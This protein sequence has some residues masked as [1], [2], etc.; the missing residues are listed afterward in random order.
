MKPIPLVLSWALV[1]GCATAPIEGPVRGEHVFTNYCSPCHGADA[2]GN[3]AYGAPA[4]AGLPD[5]YLLEQLHKYRTGLRGAHRDDTEGLRMRP[6]SRTLMT[7][8]DVQVVATHVAGMSA[9][10]APATLTGGDAA[11]GAKLFVTCTACHGPEGA[12]NEQL[13]APP[14]TVQQDWYLDRQ[15][16][17]FKAGIRG[18]NPKDQWGLTMRPMAQTLPDDQAIKDVVAH[19]QTLP[20]AGHG[21]ADAAGH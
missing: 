12:G 7:E 1:G 14:L 21:S 20:Q 5:W 19:I 4:I 3:Q 13:H 16:H 10:R 15:L 11:N 17:K 18:A 9:A 8:A 6:M 2:G